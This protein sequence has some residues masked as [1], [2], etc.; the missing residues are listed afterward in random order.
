MDTLREADTMKQVSKRPIAVIVAWSIFCI[1]F[2]SALSYV[3][4]AQPFSGQGNDIAGNL[5]SVMAAGISAVA[6][7]VLWLQHD[8]DD[9]PR[10]IWKYFSFGLWAWVA[11]DAIWMVYNL[12]LVEVPTFSLADAFYLAGYCFLAAALHHQYRILYR[13]TRRQDLTLTSVIVTALL[14]G[15]LLVQLAALKFDFRQLT[16]GRYLNFL[17][18]AGELAIAVV[19]L[20]Y[21]LNF[22]RGALARPWFGLAIFALADAF[23]AWLI[24][25]GSYAFSVAAGNLPSLI[26]DASYVAAY[27]V[28]TL[29]LIMHLLLVKYGPRPPKAS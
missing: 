14:L 13:P 4:L 3:Y 11:G 23:Y 26:A 17:Y 27:L 10:R 7:T 28:L 12:T 21:S 22:G 20:V 8:P 2:L 18:A 25:S 5:F 24:E 9:P 16:L 19:A 1:L 6:A 15:T 29:G